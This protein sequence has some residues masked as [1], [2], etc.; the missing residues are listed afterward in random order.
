M[1]RRCISHDKAQWL[2]GAR[3]A[4]TVTLVIAFAAMVGH[5]GATG[6]AGAVFAASLV[7]A[8]LF[9]FLVRRINHA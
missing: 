9:V 4:G 1:N 5:Y 6:A 7:T 3:I 8:G 2:L